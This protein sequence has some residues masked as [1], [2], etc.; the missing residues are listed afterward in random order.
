MKTTKEGLQIELDLNNH[1]NREVYNTEISGSLHSI[2]TMGL[3]DG[4]GIRTLFFLQGCPLKCQYCHNPDSQ[5]FMGSKHITVAEVVE[6]ANRYREYYEAS[7]GGVTFSGG[8]PLMQGAFLAKALKAL[9][10]QGITTCVDTSGYGVKKYY[11]DIL[12]YTDTLLLDIKHVTDEQHLK[13][14]GR[15]MS[16]ILS[17]IEALKENRFK[18]NVVIR[19]VMVPGET[20]HVKH[21]ERLLELIAP[22]EKNIEKIEILPYHKSGIEKYSQLGWTYELENVP[23]MDPA[24][25]SEFE[26]LINQKLKVRQKL[27]KAVS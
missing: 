3:V 25:A 19:H 18:G 2:E 4:P 17:F 24:V 6:I 13:L 1:H 10:D 21:M 12:R 22:I 5:H 9:K 15:N 14:T 26:V 16:G 27:K 7:G 8:E 11:A 20:D 23:A